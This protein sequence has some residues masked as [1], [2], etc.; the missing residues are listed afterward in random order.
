M[1][2]PLWAL[3]PAL[4]TMTCVS[5]KGRA[6]RARGG[7]STRSPPEWPKTS[8]PQQ[9]QA[10]HTTSPHPHPHPP[11]ATKL[12]IG[13]VAGDTTAAS[14]DA[15]LSNFGHVIDCS[16]I[17]NRVRRP[18]GGV[19]G[20]ERGAQRACT[21]AR[22]SLS[23]CLVPHAM[24]HANPTHPLPPPPPQH[25]GAPRG[26]GFV[27]FR[28]L[29]AAEAALAHPHP[30]RVDGRQVEVKRVVPHSVSRGS[31]AHLAT[32]RNNRKLFVGGLPWSVGTPDFVTFFE[33][34]GPIEDAVVMIDR[35]TERCVCEAGGGAGVCDRS[36]GV[37]RQHHPPEIP[38]PHP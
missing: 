18:G 16:L 17:T 7:G 25:N 1:T 15:Y 20:W 10:A 12:F 31:M 27:V 11:T 13:G 5:A 3:L 33:R 22:A 34:F 26:F 19:G 9:K 38:P 35:D 8:A 24:R 23:A 30:H 4:P 37:G 2:P 14:V 28:D 36:L 32:R 6:R 21:G 29:E